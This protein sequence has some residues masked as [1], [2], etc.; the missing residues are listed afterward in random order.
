MGTIAGR[1][2]RWHLNKPDTPVEA[3]PGDQ[4]DENTIASSG[5]EFDRWTGPNMIQEISQ[6]TGQLT[7]RQDLPF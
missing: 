5:W 1:L 6:A 3:I 4:L 7:K 2:L